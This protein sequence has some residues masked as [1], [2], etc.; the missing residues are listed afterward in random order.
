VTLLGCDDGWCGEAFA[1]V[2]I[3]ELFV[4]L[5]LLVA[6]LSGRKQDG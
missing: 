5:F 6:K 4:A 3:L 1:V 2:V